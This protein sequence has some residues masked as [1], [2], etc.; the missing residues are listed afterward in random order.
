MTAIRIKERL[1][2]ENVVIPYQRLKELN[3]QEVEIII[4]P[5]QDETKTNCWDALLAIKGAG[6]GVYGDIDGYIA[7][8]RN[9]W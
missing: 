4:L 8:L 5:A 7:G 1:K 9:E 2:N 6:K 3:S